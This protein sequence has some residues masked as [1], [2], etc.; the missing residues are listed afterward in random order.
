MRFSSQ[1]CSQSNLPS[2]LKARVS[3]SATPITYHGKT[4]LMLEV[5]AG[6]EPVYFNDK[7]YERD[8]AN[9]KEVTGADQ[10]KIFSLFR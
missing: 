8:G 1:T 4:V 6:Q 7:M 3:K 9:C 10:A 2:D 5:E